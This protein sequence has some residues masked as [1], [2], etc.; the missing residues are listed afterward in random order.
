[1]S[2]ERECHDT[3]LVDLVS[4]VLVD[5]NLHTDQRMRLHEQIQDLLRDAHPQRYHAA[6]AH[7]DAATAAMDE[8]QRASRVLAAM[9]ADPNV[10][11][12]TRLRLFEQIPRLVEQAQAAPRA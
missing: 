10:H 1:M 6:A 7:V 2:D 11:T 4:S 8:H 9:L 3:A 5:P 12:D